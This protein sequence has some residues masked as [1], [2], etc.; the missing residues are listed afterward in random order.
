[1]AELKPRA[2]GMVLDSEFPEIRGKLLELAAALD[3]IHRGAGAKCLESDT[4]ILRIASSLQALTEDS[5]DR[6]AKIQAIFSLA[7][8]P[9]WQRPRMGA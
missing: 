7:Y 3:R 5:P 8:D 6:A 1:M 4:R 2:A 9:K